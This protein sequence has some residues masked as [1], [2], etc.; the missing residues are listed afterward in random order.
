MVTDM[1]KNFSIYDDLYWGITASD[2]IGGYMAWGG[3][4]IQG[5]IDGSVVP[6]ATAGSIPFLP[7]ETIAVLKHLKEKY[8]QSYNRYGFIDAFN[9]TIN[10]W[11]PDVIGIDVGIS[12]L[13]A[14]NHRTRF[15]WN[16]FMKDESVQKSM[17]IVGFRSN[18]HATVF[19]PI[20]SLNLFMV[21]S[22]IFLLIL[23]H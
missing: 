20:S 7:D 15:V 23:N 6:C 1:S 17:N 13:M 14:E 12:M 22:T 2:T 9:P 19:S 4:P 21:I 18:N 10:W 11:N 8:P 3:P 5:P 16:T